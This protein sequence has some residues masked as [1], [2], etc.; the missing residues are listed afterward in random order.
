MGNIMNI[1]TIAREYIRDDMTD[2]NFTVYDRGI[3]NG[4]YSFE[5]STLYCNAFYLF[6]MQGAHVQTIID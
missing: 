4:V 3:I 2:P 1:E 6:N 5:V